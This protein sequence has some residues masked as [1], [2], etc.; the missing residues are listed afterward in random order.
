MKKIVINHLDKTFVTADAATILSEL[1]VEHPA[2]R[3][4]VHA[5][6]AQQAEVGDGAN[7]VVSLAGE[8]LAGAE[9]LLRDGLH[10]S[11]VAD[12]YAKTAA[13]VRERERK[14][15]SGCVRG[16]AER[17]VARALHPP[18]SLSFSPPQH[19]P[20]PSH[21]PSIF[22][23]S[24]P[25]ALDI[26]EALV[27]P[28]SETLDLRDTSA[29]AGRLAAPVGAKHAAALDTLAPLIARACAS[30]CPANPA[31]FNVDNVRV[32]KV[33]GGVPADSH[34]V[35]G[36][37]LKRGVEGAV[38][39]VSDAKVAVYAQ[40]FDTTG[41]ETK[42]TVLLRSGAELEAYSRQEED[43]VAALVDGVAAAG[44]KAVIAG[45]AFGEVA[46]HFLDKAG[47]LALRVPSKF[48]LRRLCRATGATALARVGA[49][50]AAEC[51]YA[52]TVAVGEVGGTKVVRV[53][54]ASGA[55]G[56]KG[57]QGDGSE[58]SAST[59]AVTTLVLRGA[60]D[61]LLDELERGVDAGV[62]AFK[63]LG[64]DARAVPAGGAAEAEVA[65]RLRTAAER[66]PGLAAYA[67]RAFA[68]ALDVVPRT[69]AENAGLDATA[70]V[71]SLAAAHADGG[72]GPTP[73]PGARLGLDLETGTPTDLSEPS[74]GGLTDLFSARWW[75]LKLAADAAVTVLRVDQIIMAK[76]AGGPRAPAGG[77]DWDDQD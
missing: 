59:S 1:E 76:A 33:A 71:A 67:I 50:T 66:A 36:L 17:R 21:P 3:L 60:T 39:A 12:G 31:N 68:A 54:Q 27:I 15:E 28:G 77:G 56:G 44:V 37:V 18:F 2:A 43:A 29:V 23:L 51:G 73:G 34:A 19:P 53:S 25:Q 57:E 70:V 20:L 45:G 7:L 22:L 72:P 35:P 13:Q 75:G 32:V 64:R 24:N 49:P 63:A 55:E 46:L 10:P 30:V 62:N 41:P 47:I 38:T 14:R 8:L 16:R 48:D 61:A 42:G 9:A 65:A 69:L 40:G 74:N 4:L 5:A 52:A 11:E 58:A 26:L 6:K